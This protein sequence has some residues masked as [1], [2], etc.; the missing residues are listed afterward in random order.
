VPPLLT[1]ATARAALA[2]AAGAPAAAGHTSA[3]AVS[4][5]RRGLQ[6][7]AAGRVKG[8]AVLV[9]AAGLTVLGAGAL[10]RQALLPRPEEPQPGAAAPAPAAAERP[11]TDRYGDPLP[12]GALA[13]LGTVRFRHGDQIYSLA[14]S[15]DGKTIAAGGYGRISLWDA[16]T[17]KPLGDLRGPGPEGHV[18]S[19]RFS[20]DGT[21]LAAAGTAQGARQDGRTVLWDLAARRPRLTLAHR[22]WARCLAISPDGTTLAVGCD[23]EEFGLWE[24]ATGKER[25]RLPGE[26]GQGV[27]AVAFS[28]DG[29][30]LATGGADKVVRLWDWAA[31]REVGR[32]D[33]GSHVRSVAFSPDG[34]ALLTGQDG[35][36]FVRLWDI[37]ERKALRDFKGHKGWKGG[38]FPGSS[39]AVAFSPDGRTAAS[40]GDDGA[41]LLWDAATGKLRDRHQNPEGS[42]HGVV[43]S[44]DGKTLIAGT[45]IGRIQQFDLATGKELHLFD[46]HSS[47]MGDMAL[48]P[49]GKTLATASADRT[50]RLW[51]LGTGRTTRVLRGHQGGVYA[52]HFSPD[53]RTLAS[54]GGDGTVRLWDVASGSMRKLTDAHGWYSRAAFAPDGKLLASAG[55]DSLVRLWDP[56]T[57]RELAQLEGHQG[58]IVGLV[59]SPDGKWLATNGESYVGE[60]GVREDKTLRLWDVTKR[61]E[62]RKLT[63]GYP[64]SGRLGFTPDSRTFVYSDQD[65]LH[66]VDVATGRPLRSFPFTGVKDFAFASGGQWLVTVGED[67]AVRFW[68]LSTGLELHR[69]ELS[70]CGAS[71]VAVTPDGRT[72]L[73]LNRDMT[74][75]LWD[76]APTGGVR[77]KPDDLGPLWDDLA[78][79]AGAKAYRAVWALAA[80]P[81]RTVAALRKALPGWLREAAGRGERIR[82]LL[83]ELDNTS[84][85]RR[86]AASKDLAGLGA[87]AEPALRRVLAG[88]PSAE[89]RR[90][91]ETLLFGKGPP[92]TPGTGDLRLL[93][94]AAVLERIGTEGARQ[95][96]EEMAGAVPGTRLELEARTALEHLA[97]S[98]RSVP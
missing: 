31:G 74:V 71:R 86:E 98:P 41:V 89:V 55:G 42:V 65:T 90:R 47:G 53:G 75:L 40:G 38:L 58:Y 51:D 16:A 4:L 52:V 44:P 36:Q 94:A 28:P 12:P 64:Y 70:D 60:K 33:A 22:S 13:R 84:F 80:E 19:L 69:V 50:V 45:T 67:R 17:G 24:A 8:A 26:F 46:E 1:A 20:P 72:L 97:R 10:A 30:L 88:S 96:L 32:L 61:A 43:F 48:S 93:R 37:V 76:L 25:P 9:L 23:R 83:A 39:Y 92:A 57:G 3:G 68:E 54:G 14:L 66:F 29:K 18:F 35:P 11:R 15:P 27:S 73:T 2:F 56:A 34:K 5:A 95:L 85:D 59:F 77:P 79:P 78:A 7:L 81:E 91:V 62:H 63:R 82:R 49:D 87:D 6:G 21:T